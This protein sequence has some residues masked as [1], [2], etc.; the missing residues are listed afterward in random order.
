MPAS[1]SSSTRQR[2][3]IASAQASSSAR[4]SPC[5]KR[6]AGTPARPAS[7]TA[8]SAARAGAF[9]VSSRAARPNIR[10]GAGP[11]PC[12]ARATVSS[13]DSSPA[14]A[15]IWKLRASPIRARR[16][17]ASRVMSAPSSNTWPDDGASVPIICAISV[18]FPAPFGPISACSSPG[19]MLSET[20]R[21]TTSAPKDL[22]S[23]RVAR[24]GPIRRSP[25]LAQQHEQHDRRADDQPPMLGQT[26]RYFLDQNEADGTKCRALRRR[27]AAQDHHHQQLARVA[28][29]HEGRAD[30]LAVHAQQPAG[31]PAQCAGDGVGGQPNTC[32]ADAGG[33]HACLALS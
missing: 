6:A 24:I 10:N 25:A 8:S 26:A 22:C 23:S 19:A 30:E 31:Q 12:T 20:P 17:G 7:P 33:N 2:G 29:V 32:D 21:V 13:A 11:T 15:V 4:C 16:C 18:V 1:G 28:P 3:D 14:S 27:G 9:N 5:D